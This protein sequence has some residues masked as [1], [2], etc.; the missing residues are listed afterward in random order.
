MWQSLVE[1]LGLPSEPLAIDSLRKRKKKLLGTA[2]T[3]FLWLQGT[4]PNRKRPQFGDATTYFPAKWRL[5]N[6]RKIPYWW[7]ISTQIWEVL[8]I[9]WTKFST[10]HKHFPN[11]GS[12]ASPV[13]N[14]CARFS[15]VILWGNKWRR[16]RMSAVFS[17]LWCAC[18]KFASDVVFTSSFFALGT[19]IRFFLHTA[20]DMFSSNQ[21]ARLF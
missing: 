6:V 3:H 1:A 17:S 20:P 19:E 2:G 13:W 14:F 10:N 11:L 7:R 18:V 16:H 5:R 9:E 4:R 12:D 15:D 21:E 8:V